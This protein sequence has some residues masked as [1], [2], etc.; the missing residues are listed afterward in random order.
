LATY[1][2]IE[3]TD[4]EMID[5]LL[6]GKIKK[7]E[8][9]KQQKLR[10]KELANR[11][12]ASQ[13]LDFNAIKTF[14]IARAKD[15]FK[16]EF[17]VDENNEM[18]FNLLSYYFIGDEDGFLKQCDLI[19]RKDE[20]LEVKNPSIKKGI[21]L[22]GNCGTGKTDMMKLFAKNTRQ[23][24]FMRSAKQISKEYLAQK[25]IPEEYTVPWKL[26]INDPATLY[27]PIAGLCIDDFGAE[28]VKNSFGNKSNV[29]GDLIEERYNAGYTGVL[30]HATSNLT[31]EQLRD[32]YGERVISRMR[33]IFNFIKFPGD[34][35]RK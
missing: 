23:V 18:F 4:E 34:D 5:C 2:H 29:I 30:L 27:Q 33:Q 25:N 13:R 3:L 1:S 28:E 10:E 8:I 24:Y 16:Y 22:V 7:E 26:L 35:R 14:M 9:I 11:K 19:K 31:A 20:R 32:Y 15:I 12:F 6:W 17:C 21:M